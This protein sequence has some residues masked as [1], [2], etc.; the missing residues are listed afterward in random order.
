V[1]DSGGASASRVEIGPAL[2][3]ELYQRADAAKWDLA[4]TDFQQ[5]LSRSLA[6]RFRDQAPS[7][8][9]AAAYLRD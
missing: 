3:R 8:L 5:A 2:S 9:D 6:S 7:P 1:N 4:E